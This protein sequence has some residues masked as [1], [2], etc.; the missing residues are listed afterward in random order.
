MNENENTNTILII[1]IIV[2]FFFLFLFFF[3]G[4]KK[5]TGGGGGGGGVVEP[6][7]TECSNYSKYPYCDIFNS[8]IKKIY[9][10]DGC[11]A[12]SRLIT[13]LTNEGKI[14]GPTDP[15]VINCT[16]NPDLCTNITAYP[17]IDCDNNEDGFIGFCD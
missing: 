15:K 13:K 4:S 17:T 1:G 7:K 11:Q 10:S 12:S 6:P 3:S 2:L 8:N 9:I 14:T 16:A 5:T